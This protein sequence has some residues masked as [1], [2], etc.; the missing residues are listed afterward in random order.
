[1]TIDSAVSSSEPQLKRQKQNEDGD[2]EMIQQDEKTSG[3]VKDQNTPKSGACKVHTIRRRT[4]V[5]VIVVVCPTSLVN[6]WATNFKVAATALA[7]S[8]ATQHTSS[9]AIPD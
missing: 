9:E 6:N 1:M 3:T 2:A 5:T 7:S 4:H 8:H